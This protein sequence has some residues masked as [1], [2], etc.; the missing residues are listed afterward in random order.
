MHF[1][2]NEI[3]LA[4]HEILSDITKFRLDQADL[5]RMRGFISSV[6]E[7]SE[8]SI[9]FTLIASAMVGARQRPSS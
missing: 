6:M 7:Y 5:I 3:S 4:S 9:S 2:S 1:C 8:N